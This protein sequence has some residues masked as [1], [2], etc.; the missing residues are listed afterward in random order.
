MIMIFL[1]N[2]V[3]CNNGCKIVFIVLK[4]NVTMMKFLLF[5]LFFKKLNSIAFLL[6]L[7]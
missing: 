6:K 1:L 7:I 3:K 4:K 2:F 5:F